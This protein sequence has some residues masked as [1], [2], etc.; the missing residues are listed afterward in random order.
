VANEKTSANAMR[1]IAIPFAG[2][3]CLDRNP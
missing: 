2:T 1:F 3:P